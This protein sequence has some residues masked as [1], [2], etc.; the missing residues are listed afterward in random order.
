MDSE[1]L[2]NKI[3]TIYKVTNLIIGNVYDLFHRKSQHKISAFKEQ[4]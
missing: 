2:N 1:I 4:V 3:Y